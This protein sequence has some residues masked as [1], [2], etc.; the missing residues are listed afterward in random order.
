[1]L[2]QVQLLQVQEAVKS[3]RL[4]RQLLEG[5][6]D[7]VG[8]LKRRVERRSVGKGSHCHRVMLIKP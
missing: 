7:N 1:M 4:K 3:K 2:E 6:L 8:L 5:K